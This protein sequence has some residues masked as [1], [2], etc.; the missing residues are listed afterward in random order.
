MFK[1]RDGIAWKPLETR[2]RSW[3]AA[4]RKATTTTRGGRQTRR[5]PLPTRRRGFLAR[6]LPRAAHGRTGA[7]AKSQPPQ[8]AQTGTQGA[9][10]EHAATTSAAAGAR[11]ARSAAGSGTSGIWVGRLAKEPSRGRNR[12][13]TWTPAARLGLPPSSAARR[14]RQRGR[15]MPRRRAGYRAHHAG[16]DGPTWRCVC[17]VKEHAD[18]APKSCCTDALGSRGPETDTRRQ[19]ALPG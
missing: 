8:L 19:T 18:P 17:A 3:Q 16:A 6:A 2:P 5:L 13:A 1:I 10:D 12:T 15:G 9:A 4:A 14:R 7:G 11:Q